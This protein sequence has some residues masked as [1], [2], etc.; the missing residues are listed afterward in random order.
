MIDPVLTQLETALDAAAMQAV[1]ASEWLPAGTPLEVRGCHI[2]SVRHK[3]GKSCLIRYDVA[4]RNVQS[5]VE[6]RQILAA[7]LHQT[8]HSEARWRKAVNA[9]V[10]AVAPMPPV[11]HIERLGLVIWAFPN[12]RKLRGV[13]M[14]LD[15]RRLRDDLLPR[16]LG[17]AVRA[18]PAPELVR[19]VPEHGC[20]VRVRVTLAGG[21]DLVLYGKVQTESH[22]AQ[23][24]ARARELGREAWFDAAS[25]SLWQRELPG[26]PADESSSMAACAAAVA[27]LHQSRLTGLAPA[28]SRL[29]P[30][31]LGGGHSTEIAGLQ[32]EI[33]RRQTSAPAVAALHG[34]LHLR[35]FLV[36]DGAAQ[37]ID[38]DTLCTGN[39]LD[40]LGSF[41]ASLYHRAA[42]HHAPLSQVDAAVAEF[43]HAYASLTPWTVTAR[44]LATHTAKALVNERVSRAM[45]RRKGDVAAD[46]LATARRLLGETETA[47]DVMRRCADAARNVPGQ[48]LDVHFKTYLKPASWHKSQVTVAWH[49]ERGIAVERFGGP[50]PAAWR[51]PHD[52]AAPWMAQAAGAEAVRP[53]LPVPAETVRM[54][55]LTYRPEN[56]LTA[57][58][59]VTHQGRTRTIYGKTYSDN[60]GE[61]VY[62]RLTALTGLG[63]ATPPPLGYAD[64]IKTVWQDAYLGVP[65]RSLLGQ[66]QA[67]RLLRTA[68]EHL[69]ALHTSQLAVPARL[70]L[71]E[72]QADL[73]KKLSK[74]ALMLPQYAGALRLLASRLQD[75]L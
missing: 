63:F 56:R 61:Q 31:P 22:G 35:N 66:P 16:L 34:D 32:A 36:H 42:L 72:M 6:F 48:A 1:L 7:R 45:T 53:F 75:R 65:L 27:A 26:V 43:L 73:T 70:S 59:R 54:D 40:D 3:P 68:A 9:P 30:P 67:S 2:G 8:G 38:L 39:P 57:R 12:E 74:L 29:E 11:A 50:H 52:P 37:L 46:L 23:T 58:Y 21:E 62:A 4:L 44:D 20:T 18:V 14:L 47:T 5:G 51:F 60:R 25:G 15:A 71:P 17:R 28:P 19:Y 41:A 13:E 49:D 64:A 55:V 24:C 10:F 69:R 33:A